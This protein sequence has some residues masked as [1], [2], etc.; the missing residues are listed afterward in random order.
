MKGARIDNKLLD[1][2]PGSS[3]KIT[4]LL[5]QP[6]SMHGAP[7]IQAT[8][9][10]EFKLMYNLLKPDSLTGIIMDAVSFN[11]ESPEDGAHIMVV[12]DS[13][14]HVTANQWGTWWWFDGFGALDRE[15]EYFKIHIMDG[16]WYEL[17]LRK[18][19]SQYRLLYQ[20]GGTWKQ[21]DWSKL[22]QDQY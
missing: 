14:L 18:P 12:N 19:P 6:E 2:F 10:G 17:T 1:T 8:R 15:N 7:M 11:M 16:H 21:V 9:G 4:I 3:D 22:G 20:T 5:D 13:M